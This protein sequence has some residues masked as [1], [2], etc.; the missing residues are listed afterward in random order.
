MNDVRNTGTP[1]IPL[2]S[3]A[4]VSSNGGGLTKPRHGFHAWFA[5]VLAVIVLTYLF[6][7]CFVF[8]PL[9]FF[10]VV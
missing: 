9:A 1:F 7:S 10:K 5:N 2:V 6:I 4:A 8:L 3:L